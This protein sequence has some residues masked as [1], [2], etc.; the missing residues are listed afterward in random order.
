MQSVG[1]CSPDSPPSQDYLITQHV[2]ASMAFEVSVTVEFSGGICP[3]LQTCTTN[4]NFNLSIYH[5]S[6]V[7]TSGSEDITNYE[8]VGVVSDSNPFVIP[9]TN[10]G[11]YLAFQSA[12]TCAEISRVR[13]VYTLC[14]EV[15]NVF[16]RYSEAT[17]GVARTGVCVD[18]AVNM[19]G[20]SLEAI[21]LAVSG[22]FDFTAAGGC[23]CS[24]GFGVGEANQ[25]EG[26]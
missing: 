19:T 9:V 13:V 4:S 25:C 26:E 6:T 15:V 16:A 7:D 20:A 3:A 8:L 5:T 14:E 22:L 21:C 18:N 24:A 12:P 10:S 1:I 2:D 23:E 11:F 17:N